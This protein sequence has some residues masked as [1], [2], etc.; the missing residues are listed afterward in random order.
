MSPPDANP[1]SLPL[2]PAVQ[3][4]PPGTAGKESAW[5][6]RELLAL[7]SILLAITAISV[8]AW[9]AWSVQSRREQLQSSQIGYAFFIE[10]APTP[11]QTVENSGR[12]KVSIMIFNS[13]PAN[14]KTMVLHL[15][16]P[17]AD[18][19]L[20]SK[21]QVMSSP[22]AARI[23]VKDRLPDGN[24]QIVFD[25]LIHGDTAFL[26]MYYQVPEGQITDMVREW[27]QNMFTRTFARRFVLE[28][29]FSGEYLSFR[30][31]GAIPLTPA[32]GE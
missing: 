24:Y 12:W 2:Q 21:P 27:K 16:T 15:R 5:G 10:P 3:Q 7:A 13:G 22:A 25:N 32:G 31:F 8:S 9:V 1:P 29:F 17:P 20:H 26:S 14:V 6:L 18:V 19:F 23:E 4:A 11:G 28:F 30:N